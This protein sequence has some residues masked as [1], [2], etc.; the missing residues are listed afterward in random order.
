MFV[1]RSR[2]ILSLGKKIY[3]NKRKITQTSALGDRVRSDK[4]CLPAINSLELTKVTIVP[5]QNNK[6]SLVVDVF[7]VHFHNGIFEPLFEI[8]SSI[9]RSDRINDD[10]SALL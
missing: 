6:T 10:V 7:S 8:S 5:R 2:I 9:R 1:A 3:N 4:V